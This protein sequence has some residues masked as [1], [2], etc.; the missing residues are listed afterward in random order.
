MC[1]RL[2]NVCFSFLYKAC[3]KQSRSDNS[4]AKYAQKHMECPLLLFDLYL[5]LPSRQAQRQLPR[6]TREF[7]PGHRGFSWFSLVPPG[8]CNDNIASRARPFPYKSFPIYRSHILRS[9]DAIYCRQ[10]VLKYPDTKFYQNLLT[11]SRWLRGQTDGQVRRD[12][13]RQ[14]GAFS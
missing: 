8:N 14:T 2:K 4:R 5:N 13:L 6:L 1:I 12:I 11:V 9:F 10:I 7:L 3:W